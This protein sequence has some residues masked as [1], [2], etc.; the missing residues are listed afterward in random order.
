MT[1]LT[2]GFLV[3]MLTTGIFPNLACSQQLAEH[4]FEVRVINPEYVVGTGPTVA[5][6]EA[7]HNFHTAENRYR[8]FAKVLKLDGFRVKANTQPFSAESL[9]G[10]DVLVIS[11]SL[12]KRNV[13]DWSLPTPSAFTDTEIRAL[14]N[15]VC[16]GGSLFL[17]ADHM[18]FP[19][20]ASD[21]AKNF[22]V[23]FSNGYARP[24]HKTPGLGD[25][26]NFQNGLVYSVLT[27][28]RNPSEGIKSIRTF[29]GSA[30]IPPIQSTPIILFQRDSVS[31]E[32]KKAPGITKDARRVPIEGWCQGA[33]FPFGSGRVAV[34]G[35]AAMFTTQITGRKKT[36]MGM[37]S[38]DAKHNQQ[39]LLNIMHWLAKR[40]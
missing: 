19:G 40:L 13:R 27:K 22:G 20:A 38:P 2:R 16:Q 3:C 34:F 31:A 4:D 29:G 33:V 18:P 14:R 9:R 32:T 21:L 5:I 7:H 6:D 10:F 25:V 8:V 39:L 24:A 36:P 1:R 26:F 15:W 17:I 11:N 28:G 35:E 23:I 30:F 37:N 12:H